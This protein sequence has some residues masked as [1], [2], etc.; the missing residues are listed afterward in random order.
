MTVQQTE[1][2]FKFDRWRKVEVA[3]LALLG[4]S[5]ALNLLLLS[6]VVFD[7]P[8]PLAA[9]GIDTRFLGAVA[10]VLFALLIAFRFY[11]QKRKAEIVLQFLEN[12]Q[13]GQE[14][15]RELKQ[16]SWPI[17]MNSD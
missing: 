1:H 14:V 2:G 6:Q 8:L 11:Q 7:K 16:Q 9:T 13:A 17:K 10:I 5:I 15:E 4:A 12:Q 3:L